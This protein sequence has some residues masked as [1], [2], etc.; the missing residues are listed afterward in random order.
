MG[1]F[2]MADLA[3]NDIGY[4]VRVWTFVCIRVY[5]WEFVS[6]WNEEREHK[7]IRLT[8]PVCAYSPRLGFV[9]FVSSRTTY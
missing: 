9:C 2:E 1:P 8:I 6:G 4:Y 7:K 3:G 5:T